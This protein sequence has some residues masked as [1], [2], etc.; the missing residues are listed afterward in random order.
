MYTNT[1]KAHRTPPIL[2]I[3]SEDIGNTTHLSLLKLLSNH[4][5]RKELEELE[6]GGMAELLSINEKLS[7]LLMTRTELRPT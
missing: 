1:R 4:L 5:L 6:D 7:D 3:S 2:N